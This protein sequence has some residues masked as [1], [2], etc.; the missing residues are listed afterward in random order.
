MLTTSFRKILQFVDGLKCLCIFLD[1]DVKYFSNYAYFE[2]Q[3]IYSVKLPG[4]FKIGE[5]KPENQNHPIIFSRA[6]A[7]QTIDMNQVLY[8][9][10]L[11]LVICLDASIFI[12][13]A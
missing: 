10:L 5:G 11:V 12:I 13:F 3:L 6:D 1:D 8:Y 4:P 2:L 7:V 9:S